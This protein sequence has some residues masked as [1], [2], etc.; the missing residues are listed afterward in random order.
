M[1]SAYLG[2]GSN[3]NAERHV[4]I[5]ITWLQDTFIDAAFSPVY[6][7]PAVG[8]DGEDFL[9][10]VARVETHAGP[11]ELKHLLN[12]FEDSHGRRRDVPKFSDRTLDIDILIYDDLVLDGPELRLPRS[13]IV[14]FAHVLK[15]LYD[16]AP[17]LWHPT[18]QQTIAQLWSDYDQSSVELQ[19]VDW[20]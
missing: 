20:T 9:N 1:A 2:I 17:G 13:E 7:S 8:F 18:R 12:A 6:R 16:L 15:P 3:V 19:P 14:H 4:R 5:A 10:L 11:L